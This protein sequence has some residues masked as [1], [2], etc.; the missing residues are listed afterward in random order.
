MRVLLLM[1]FPSIHLFRVIALVLGCAILVGLFLL[2]MLPQLQALALPRQRVHV[3]KPITYAEQTHRDL[4]VSVTKAELLVDE[5]LQVTQQIMAQAGHVAEDEANRILTRSEQ[6]I[7]LIYLQYAI[8]LIRATNNVFS[9][10]FPQV[11]VAPQKMAC[12]LQCYILDEQGLVQE[13]VSI[14][15]G[16]LEIS[17]HCN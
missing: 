1:G 9:P 12:E 2:W 4:L 14:Q 3:P 15:V 11:I 10:H 16:V 13:L 6:R 8:R 17:E 7:K 5:V